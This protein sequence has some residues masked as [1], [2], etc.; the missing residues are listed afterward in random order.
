MEWDRIPCEGKSAHFKTGHWW[1][2][3]GRDVL[4][5]RWSPP[6]AT[7]SLVLSTP[8]YFSL[9]SL[10]PVRGKPCHSPRSRV[11]TRALGLV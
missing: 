11:C 4:R 2:A 8:H 1:I 7:C 6:S 3:E 5:V 10:R 9:S